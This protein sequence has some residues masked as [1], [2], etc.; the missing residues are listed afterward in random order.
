[1]KPHD[2]LSLGNYKELDCNEVLGNIVT[3]LFQ[4]SFFVATTNIFNNVAQDINEINY[5]APLNINDVATE[6][7]VKYC[8]EPIKFFPEKNSYESKFMDVQCYDYFR[9]CYV[10]RNCEVYTFRVPFEGDSEIFEFHGSQFNTEQVDVELHSNYLEIE[11]IDECNKSELVLNHYKHQLS[12]IESNIG[13]MN[14]EV[15]RYN[16]QLESFITSNI[17]SRLKMIRDKR[18]KELDLGFPRRGSDYNIREVPIVIKKR[19]SL[20]VEGI[21]SSSEEQYTIGDDVFNDVVKA[22]EYC[23]TSME[24]NPSSYQKHDEEQLRDHVLTAINGMLLI[25]STGETFNSSGHTDII[26][27]YRNHNIFIAECKIWKGKEYVYKALDQIE[28]YLSW[29]DS[30][31][32]IIIFYKNRAD[33]NKSVSE[34]NQMICVRDNCLRVIE[35]NNRGGTFVLKHPKDSQKYYRLKVLF[36][37]LSD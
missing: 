36:F 7:Y 20:D 14:S 4:N 35:Q 25:N 3:I 12:F 24:R 29:D 6:I 5:D 9:N 11:V 33:M 8:L 1:M 37:N 23:A 21:K 28:G 30:K 15:S 17:E 27:V 32:V 2:L 19:F 16:S 34:L 26:Y 22:I 18:Q 13:R 31:A 10:L